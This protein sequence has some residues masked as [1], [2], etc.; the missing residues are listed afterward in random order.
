MLAIPPKNIPDGKFTQPTPAMPD[1]V[2]NIDSLIA[3]RNYYKK[4][5][6]HLATWNKRDTPSWYV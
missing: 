1:D 6:T 4:Y 5:K 2:K 3:Y